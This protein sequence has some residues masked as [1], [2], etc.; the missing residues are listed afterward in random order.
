MIKLVKTAWNGKPI[1]YWQIGN[2]TYGSL[3]LFADAMWLKLC[4]ATGLPWTRQYPA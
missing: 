2:G 1:R 3:A 4:V